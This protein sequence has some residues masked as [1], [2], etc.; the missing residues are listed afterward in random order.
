ME[1]LT[2]EVRFYADTTIVKTPSCKFWH[3]PVCQLQVWKKGCTY[4][5]KCHFR[6]AEAQ[7]KPDK[8]SKK[9]GVK[10]SVALFKESN[11]SRSLHT[12]EEAEVFVQSLNLFVTVQVLDDT[13]AVLSL[14][15]LFEDHGCCYE[16]VSGQKP[17][18]TKEGKT[19]V[20]K[21]NN[22]VPLFVP[23]LSSN[24]GSVS[25][26]TSLPQD[27]SRGEVEI[28]SGNSR[29]SASS[30]ILRSSIRAK[31]RNGTPGNRCESWRNQIKNQKKDDRKNSDDPLADLP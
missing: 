17:Q 5:D 18:L 26:S 16:W 25:S 10:G 30:F 11:Y 21:T 7:E 6:H 29:R 14:G 15:N 13:P 22:F 31:W 4:G 24:S 23:G 20:C 19:I 8:W 2:R 9:G 3:L 27:S 12:H 28:A 1:V